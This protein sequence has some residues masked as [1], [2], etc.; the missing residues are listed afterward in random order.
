MEAA[1]LFLLVRYTVAERWW[2]LK[3]IV[4]LVGLGGTSRAA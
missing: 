3:R 4:N 1:L 2:Y